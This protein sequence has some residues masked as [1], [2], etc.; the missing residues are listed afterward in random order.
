MHGLEARVTN[1]VLKTFLDGNYRI[2]KGRDRIG[3]ALQ[4]H[5]GA[6]R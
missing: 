2:T 3:P 6:N 1:E 4:N 5:H